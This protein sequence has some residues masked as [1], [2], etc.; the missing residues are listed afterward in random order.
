MRDPYLLP[1]PPPPQPSGGKLR[2]VNWLM[3]WSLLFSCLSALTSL[4]V[5]AV[6]LAMSVGLASLVLGM[7]VMLFGEVW[8][9]GY[10]FLGGC[11]PFI[12]LGLLGAFGAQ[13][14]I[15]TH[16]DFDVS[17]RPR[18]W[19]EDQME[20]HLE[21]PRAKL[22]ARLAAVCYGLGIVG[23]VFHVG[24]AVLVGVGALA[25]LLARSFYLEPIV[26]VRADSIELQSWLGL[27]SET[28]WL[29]EVQKLE[30]D[31]TRELALILTDGA[32][33]ELPVS[34]LDM[35][36]ADRLAHIVEFQLKAIQAARPALPRGSEP[37]TSKYHRRRRRG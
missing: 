10:L 13:R 11:V 31:G 3:L 16:A 28:I 27:S 20:F 7:G 15:D 34:S 12:P 32:R 23:L 36:G 30:K 24:F 4:E 25:L 2:R 9:G 29:E 26:V 5:P 21:L 35:A 1:Q 17:Q 6:Q 22:R 14:V 19:N 8:L 37:P 33:I 18:A